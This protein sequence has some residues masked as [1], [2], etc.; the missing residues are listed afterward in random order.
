MA[1]QIAT[2]FAFLPDDI[3]AAKVAYHLHTFWEPRMIA[4]LEAHA[5]ARSDDFAP[6][7]LA[8]TRLLVEQYGEASPAH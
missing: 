1:N 4:G 8:A 2:Q 3:A 7:V 6:I 5:A